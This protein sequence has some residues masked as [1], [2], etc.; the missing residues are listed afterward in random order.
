[1]EKIEF[2]KEYGAYYSPRKNTPEIITIPA[3]QF[4]AIDGHGAPESAQFQRAI[5]ALFGISYTLKFELRK[6]GRYPDFTIAP[7][8]AQWWVAGGAFTATN[9]NQWQWRAMMMQPGFVNQRC[10]AAAVEELQKKKPVPLADALKLVTF[11]EGE[12]VQSMHVGPYDAEVPTLEKMYAFAHAKGYKLCGKHH[13]IYF[14]DPRRT[15]PE[16]LRTIVRHPVQK[17]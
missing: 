10:F 7:L 14:S 3:L 9:R 11:D 4:A 16:K 6:L 5:Q 8:E 17:G 13:E 2:K 15:A 1:M 12:V